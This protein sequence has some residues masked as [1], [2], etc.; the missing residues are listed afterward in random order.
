MII[1]YEN[2]NKD[3]NKETNKSVDDIWDDDMDFEL[4]DDAAVN[5]AKSDFASSESKDIIEEDENIQKQK[6][7]RRMRFNNPDIPSGSH[8]SIDMGKWDKFRT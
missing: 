3:L 7:R 6:T 2:M 4:Y 5:A 1:K 8:D